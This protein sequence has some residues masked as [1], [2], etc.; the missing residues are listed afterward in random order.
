MVGP[1][2]RDRAP[3]FHF[4]DY[5][6]ESGSDDE[7]QQQQQQQQPQKKNGQEAD[8]SGAGSSVGARP[9]N[10][11]GHS[12]T[13]HQIAP[14]AAEG[15]EGVGLGRRPPPIQVRLPADHHFGPPPSSFA[16]RGS[17]KQVLQQQQQPQPHS[18]RSPTS[19]SPQS[20]PHHH[21]L[22]PPPS[23][24]P[25]DSISSSGSSNPSSRP[26]L[27]QQQ[28]QQQQ[29]V[30]N[31]NNLP[32]PPPRTIV[33]PRQSGLIAP[34]GPSPI[35]P[36]RNR[37]GGGV[38]FANAP[39]PAR[40]QPPHNQYPHHH[41]PQ[42][43]HMQ[44]QHPQ[45]H[46]YAQG[47]P[48][49]GFGR[50][51]PGAAPG[52]GPSGGELRRNVTFR[53]Q[54]SIASS[55]P[56]TIN[57]G[58]RH[59]FA[60][61]FDDDDGSQDHLVTAP[62]TI[63][64]NDDVELGTLPRSASG[65]RPV[66]RRG[67]TV[68]AYGTLVG[69]RRRKTVKLAPT[70]NF[71]IKE[72]LP[73][74]LLKQ[75]AYSQGDEFTTIRYTAATTDP[76]QFGEK[77]YTLR[78]VSEYGRETELAIVV[79]MYNEGIKELNRT[80]FGIFQNIQYMCQKKKWGWE[81]DG[82][83]KIVVVLVGDGRKKCNLN[84]LL[85]LQTMGVYQEGLPQLAVNNTPTT[86]HIF[87]STS[88]IVLDPN[89]QMWT[90]NSGIPPVQFIF[91]LK[92]RNAKKINSHR[93]FFNAICPILK[94]KVCLLVDV[95]TR[96]MQASI[97]RLWK[98][99]D[100]N[101]HIAGA[102]GEIKVDMTW[103]GVVNPLVASQNFEYKISNHLDKAL[104]SVFG[105][106][107][108]LPGAF[109]AYRYAALL[110]NMPNRGPLASYF[111]GERRDDIAPTAD[112]STGNSPTE[113]FL[114]NLFLAED[115]I[116]ALELVAK[117]LSQW[118]LHYVAKASAETD[119]PD[120]IPE[121]IAQRRRWL[122]GSFFA[123]LYAIVNIGRTLRTRHSI[124]R[125]LAFM[126][127]AVYQ[128]LSLIFTWFG[129]SQFA[130]IFY[131][132]F[133]F[134]LRTILPVP[135]AKAF[136]CIYP[137]LIVVLFIA[138]LGNRPQASKIIYK[139]SMVFFAFIGLAMMALLGLKIYNLAD[140]GKGLGGPFEMGSGMSYIIGLSATYGVYLLGSLLQRDPYHMVT[141]L[142]QYMLLLPSYINV[143]QI[144]AFCNLHDVTWGTKGDNTMSDLPQVAVAVT[145]DGAVVADVHVM[146]GGD[147]EN[148]WKG[149]LD[150]IEDLGAG[151]AKE[152]P[153]KVDPRTAQEDAYKS[154][155][156]NL[157]LSWLLSNAIVFAGV[158]QSTANVSDTYLVYL[159]YATAGL[160][161]IRLLGVIAYLLISAS[162]HLCGCGDSRRRRAKKS[163]KDAADLK[164]SLSRLDA[165]TD[166]KHKVADSKVYPTKE[167]AP[168]LQ[169]GQRLLGNIH[170][171]FIIVDERME[172]HDEARLF[173]AS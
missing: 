122:N 121:F 114:S 148:V 172:D 50:V 104:E 1:T 118:T 132:L 144:Y 23:P 38:S 66:V 97:Y 56:S 59:S 82:W 106:I 70:G 65:G 111:K 124:G 26:L 57:D 12:H 169:P 117:P 112:G 133:S 134:E 32:R 88:Q 154:F 78:T 123:Q 136:F 81:A 2:A 152:Q 90:T 71:V 92:E 101:P 51:G 25:Y 127:Q 94:P 98:A 22:G 80:L 107:G 171:G 9:N 139:L 83:K 173:M 156:T 21:P 143:L 119:V 153:S 108:V 93:W 6:A 116:L 95:G 76:D 27:Q 85:A 19:L 110:D 120:S 54:Q 18:P 87:E 77:G 142:F 100:R 73:Q 64:S 61:Y 46:Q 72:R 8:H 74:S 168:P 55:H 49:P 149:G 45:D 89:L 68:N 28:Q 36:P 155:R 41:Q 157:L 24:N 52:M 33:S 165:T 62:S 131:F 105:Y 125:K 42:Q 58:D 35:R 146:S 13:T 5:Y 115:R 145:K 7:Q 39:P 29:G 103:R 102:C 147:R 170:N 137:G 67:T 43:Q 16:P 138:S 60:E 63:T 158:T 151:R 17:S 10:T 140:Q 53:E 86:A 4:E 20:N 47:P 163:R 3:S 96:P 11:A 164:H 34:Q 128:I 161:G 84:V 159:L 130:I 31:N 126:L 166:S 113:V 129:P 30:M 109:S 135:V 40:F 69:P 160:S 99:F 37:E 44:H 48:R 15:G 14:V 91:C 162:V 79:T 141:S 150:R 167:S 75:V